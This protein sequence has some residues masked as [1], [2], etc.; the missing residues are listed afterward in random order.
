MMENYAKRREELKNK[1]YLLRSKSKLKLYALLSELYDLEL[2]HDPKY[3]LRQLALDN[4]MHE[5]TLYR[6]MSWRKATP[7][8]KQMVKERKIDMS[9]ACRV[10]FRS[11]PDIQNKMVYEAI[12]NNYTYDEIDIAVTKT[13]M[14]KVKVILSRKETNDFNLLRDISGHCFKLEN[15]LENITQLANGHKPQIKMELQSLRDKIDVALARI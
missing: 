5:Q 14:N 6:L 15:H 13:G 8:I 9:K 10:L 3:S 11:N 12:K 1:I 4:D 2:K 7:Y